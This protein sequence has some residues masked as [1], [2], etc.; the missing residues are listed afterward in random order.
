MAD[1][2]RWNHF[3]AWFIDLLLESSVDLVQIWPWSVMKIQIDLKVKQQAREKTR[4]EQTQGE[5][6]V[7]EGHEQKWETKSRRETNIQQYD[8][9]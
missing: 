7:G 6:A 4:G 5:K 8:E 9:N 3:L 2:T 1:P